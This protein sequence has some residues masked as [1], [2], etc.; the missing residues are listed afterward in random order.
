M[1]CTWPLI[2]VVMTDSCIA[3]RVTES[4]SF[5]AASASSAP[6]CNVISTATP[7]SE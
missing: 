3:R 7:T 6:R 4:L 1:N 5:S 2:S